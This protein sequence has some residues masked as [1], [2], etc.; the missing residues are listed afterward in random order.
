[1]ID[2]FKYKTQWLIFAILLG[3]N[4]ILYG[5]GDKLYLG[6]LLQGSNEKFYLS[7]DKPKG[8]NEKLYGSGDKLQGFLSLKPIA[9]VIYHK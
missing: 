8:L 7:G 4:K 2:G 5:S 9:Q 1:M 6:D 3:S